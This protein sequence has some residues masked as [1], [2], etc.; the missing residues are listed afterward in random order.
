M[1]GE[2]LN[3]LEGLRGLSCMVV[4][5]DHC[6]NEFMPSFRH[7]GSHGLTG[8]I[9]DIIA[10]SP[11]N[12]IYSGL[13][14]V[15]IFFVLSGYVL[16]CKFHETGNVKYAF[17]GAIKRYFR[18]TGPVVGSMLF[19]YII[20][21]VCF[22][23]NDSKTPM[24]IIDVLDE[25]FI[26]VFFIGGSLHNGPLWTMKTE[27]IGSLLVFALM[28]VTNSSRYRAFTYLASMVY[29]YDSNFLLFI[30]GMF[31]CDVYTTGYLK[32]FVETKNKKILIPLLLISVYL[33]SYPTVRNHVE[34]SGIYSLLDIDMSGGEVARF[35]LWHVTGVMLLF[36]CVTNLE[37]LKNFFSKSFCL[38]LGRLSF[39]VYVLHYP[40]IIFFREIGWT[41]G[42]DIASLFM[43][44]SAVYAIAI[45]LSFPFELYIDRGSV[46]VSN[47]I[48]YKVMGAF[49]VVASS[50]DRKRA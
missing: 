23:F 6:V 13:T 17:S 43:L 7:M 1:K 20:Y 15:F 12:I 50:L 48:S 37:F 16:S 30:F 35:R 46:R 49:S 28:L 11:L 31:L 24:S 42:R 14:P 18:L 27:L 41:G 21:W 2:K 38:L 5:F 44:S 39:S 40:V 32:E 8:W 3:Y 33:I 22:A 19:L 34:V 29:F 4:I 47:Y 9:K 10:M 26:K 36:Y 45:G 25:S